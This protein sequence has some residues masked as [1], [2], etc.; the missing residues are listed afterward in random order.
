MFELL[1]ECS[2]VDVY[3]DTNYEHE[4]NPRFAEPIKQICYVNAA[5]K[6]RDWDIKTQMVHSD[7]L[8]SENEKEM[9][10]ISKF[11]FDRI[12]PTLEAMDAYCKNHKKNYVCSGN[13]NFYIEG[14]VANYYMVLNPRKGHRNLHIE[15]FVK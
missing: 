1:S 7:L 14:D 10:E 6:K 13:Y 15:Q 2:F 4:A 5:C 8:D 9:A 11:L 3:L 12:C